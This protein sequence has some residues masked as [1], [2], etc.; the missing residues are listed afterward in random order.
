MVLRGGAGFVNE[1]GI[2]VGMDGVSDKVLEVSAASL[3]DERVTLRDMSIV[4]KAVEEGV[5]SPKQSCKILSFYSVAEKV[6]AQRS[7]QRQRVK[8]DQALP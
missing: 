5:R 3:A 1:V 2:V 4:C 6:I 7:K 8:K